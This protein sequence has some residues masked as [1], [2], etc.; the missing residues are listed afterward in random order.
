MT[1]SINRDIDDDRIDETW[2]E[3]EVEWYLMG[4]FDGKIPGLIRRV[5]R[6]LD[7]SQRGLAAL[8]EVSQ[9]V[10]ARWET[11]R[12]SPRA[13]VLHALLRMARLTV[14]IQDEAGDEIGPMRDDGARDRGGRRFPAHVDLTVRGWWVPRG[15]AST[16]F[17]D[18]WIQRSRTR[19]VPLVRFRT[20][21]WRRM[22]ERRLFGKPDDHPSLRQL[23]AEARHLDDLKADRRQRARGGRVW[24]TALS[25]DTPR[26]A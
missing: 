2:T 21:P 1:G 16:A 10:V 5:R 25:A 19:N 9:S 17:Y 4:P 13:S 23:G 8:L 15:A 24:P 3:Q 11:G 26:S 14:E 20:C 7:V 18:L 6:I 12:V 22:V